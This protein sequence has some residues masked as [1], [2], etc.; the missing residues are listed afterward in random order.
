MLERGPASQ[1]QVGTVS[2]SNREN[3]VRR[4]FA[5]PETLLDLQRTRGNA[6][7]QRLVRRKLAVSQAGDRY[8]QDADRVADAVGAKKGR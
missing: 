5:G 7:V 1:I 8:E 2:S 4:N 3:V 6:F